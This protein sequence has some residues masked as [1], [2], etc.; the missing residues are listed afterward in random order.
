[1]KIYA[2][3]DDQRRFVEWLYFDT[4]PVHKAG[5]LLPQVVD[6][7]PAFNASTHKAIEGAPVVGS[8]SVRKTFAVVPLSQ[9]ELAEVAVQAKVQTVLA[10]LAALDAGSGTTAER[11]RRLETSLAYVARDLYAFATTGRLNPS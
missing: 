3:I 4:L 9:D 6:N 8:E 5:R 1:M 10:G 11:I 2:K 7:L